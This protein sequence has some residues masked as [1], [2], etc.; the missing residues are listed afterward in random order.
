M[1]KNYKS[2]EFM[3]YFNKKENSINFALLSYN[4]QGNVQMI[5]NHEL[6]NRDLYLNRLIAFQ[7]TD[8]VKVITGIRRCGKSSLLKLMQEH[9]LNTGVKQKQI[10]EMN[11]ESFQFKDMSAAELYE[12]VK[13]HII[14]SQRMYFFFDEVQRVPQWEDAIN[15]FRVD[16]N[17]DIY[18]TGS[19]AYML[20]SEYSTYLSGR[21]IEIK[22]L[23]LSFREF[24]DFNGL[25]IL[26][27]NTLGKNKKYLVDKT[28]NK[29]G[30]DEA[31]LS[32]MKFGGMPGI[33]D[34]GFDQEKAMVLLEGIYSTVI[35]RDI[36][37]RENR[38]GQKKLT[39]PVLLKKIITFLS[40]N[41]GNNVSATT[42]GG[43][44]SNE[45]L[46]NN[47]KRKGPP[48]AHTVQSYINA[49]LD[50]YFFYEV[51]RFDLKGKDFL[52]TLGKY[53]I[54]D[55]GLRNLLLGFRDRDRG[56]ALENI[57]YFELIRRGYDV[58]IGKIDNKE[59]DFIATKADEKLYIQV[60]ESMID[61][62]V[63]KREL[64]PLQKLK[65][66]YKKIIL[67]LEPGLNNNY[68][69]ILSLNIIDW[70]ISD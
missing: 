28:G 66:N 10:I 57:V 26:E 24:I 55:I 36:L 68:E 46:I 38:R 15:S 17:C 2:S 49:L 35:M 54:V 8:P 56:H 6:K 27:N 13:T 50:S 32:Y 4:S 67:S 18:V 14:E 43:T 25:K 64:A 3:L 11:F 22:M 42:I 53:Y 34:I 39:D 29:F 60:T 62:N 20:S 19:N 21:C 47:E 1:H 51:K 41:I 40:D 45:G 65:D 37:E 70:L 31:F 9:L 48:S 44:L 61:E 23:P 58:S 16:F 7:D 52:R 5:N 63:Q 33:H 30:L 12:Y 59:I 69:G